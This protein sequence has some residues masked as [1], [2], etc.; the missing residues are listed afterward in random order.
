MSRCVG[1]ATSPKWDEGI[2]SHLIYIRIVRAKLLDLVF[3]M[4]IHETKLCSP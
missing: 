3:L 1:G 2:Y 4:K